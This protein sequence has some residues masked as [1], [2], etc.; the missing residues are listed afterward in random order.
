MSHA[1]RADNEITEAFHDFA[2]RY[3]RAFR[4][5]ANATATGERDRSTD[6]LAIKQA[7]DHE[8]AKCFVMVK[9]PDWNSVAKAASGD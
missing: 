9:K 2:E 6:T 1:G 8:F 5:H 7:I 4:S 3:S